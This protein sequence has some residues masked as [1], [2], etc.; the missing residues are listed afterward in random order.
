MKV[1]IRRMREEDISAAAEVHAAAFPRQ[2]FSKEW[3]DC[4]FRSFPKSQCFVAETEGKIVGVIFWTEK[5]GFRKEA[6]VEL[7]Q[8]A[9]SPHLQGRGIGTQLIEKSL[10]EVAYKISERGAQLKNII[11]NT[12]SDNAAQELYKKTL[13]AEPVARVSGIFTADEV[14]MIAKDVQ[15]PAM[16]KTT[17]R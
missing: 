11:V 14:Y 8:I 4:V 1:S 3:L 16:Q 2:T 15:I 13:G 17:S 10:P 6:F 5:S 7:E 12:R 9:V